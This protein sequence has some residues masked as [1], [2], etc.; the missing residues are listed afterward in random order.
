MKPSE[1]ENA[2]DSASLI[3]RAKHRASSARLSR[4]SKQV[5]RKT[6]AGAMNGSKAPYENGGEQG[7]NAVA[8]T[9]AGK[10]DREEQLFISDSEGNNQARQSSLRQRKS[11]DVAASNDNGE[12]RPS[13]SNMRQNA[14]RLPLH[15]GPNRKYT[16][17][18]ARTQAAQATGTEESNASFRRKRK[19]PESH[20]SNSTS[21]QHDTGREGQDGAVKHHSR[22]VNSTRGAQS[23]QTSGNS[24][25]RKSRES[26]RSSEDS[27]HQQLESASSGN[28]DQY[29]EADKV[30]KERFWC[31]QHE[32]LYQIFAARE[33]ITN[34]IPDKQKEPN[35]TEE[36][37]SNIVT[38][39]RELA[40]YFTK[41]TSERSQI[42]E[43]FT[44]DTIDFIQE[45]SRSVLDL[46]NGRKNP[47]TKAKVIRYLYAYGIPA[48]VDSVKASLQRYEDSSGLPEQ[49]VANCN[50]ILDC[51]FI[52]FHGAEEYRKRDPKLFRT[53]FRNFAGVRDGVVEPLKQVHIAFKDA[54]EGEHQRYNNPAEAEENQ[55]Q[56]VLER[57]KEQHQRLRERNLKEATIKRDQKWIRLHSVRRHVEIQG[58]THLERGKVQYL[59]D[60]EPEPQEYDANGEP[61]ER[62]T[63]LRERESLPP[64][65]REIQTRLTGKRWSPE[66]EAALF[67]TFQESSGPKVYEKI[68]LEHCTEQWI[69]GIHIRGELRDYNVTDIVSYA[70]GLKNLAIRDA[71]RYGE[72]TPEWIRAIW[73]PRVVRVQSDE[74]ERRIARQIAELE[75]LLPQHEGGAAQVDGADEQEESVNDGDEDEYSYDEDDLE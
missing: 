9:S 3:N 43:K 64:S 71:E 35:V 18:S 68:F 36:E 8:E 67:N 41:M 65:S 33:A 12:L 19:R 42:D 46:L 39:S 20:V 22:G 37:G 6:V 30:R 58:Q 2:R 60:T 52:L 63:A 74:E 25:M 54:L 15:E 40:D 45:G 51:I 73:D 31:G 16:R 66:A 32:R 72:E 27:T 69:R 1:Q 4:S 24:N 14:I 29:Q 48:L 11:K 10:D 17:S 21:Q 34:S 59:A 28:N 13:S 55:A 7:D 49:V 38:Y 62:V 56:P 75:R 23:K 61:F 44:K 57:L 26:Y 5:V 70:M 47:Q 50:S 53:G